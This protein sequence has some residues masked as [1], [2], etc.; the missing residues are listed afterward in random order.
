[1]ILISQ[2]DLNTAVFPL[3]RATDAEVALVSLGQQQD[4]PRKESRKPD[5]GLGTF[6]V[7]WKETF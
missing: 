6:L 1:M 2:R 5:K 4:K 7:V 3:S